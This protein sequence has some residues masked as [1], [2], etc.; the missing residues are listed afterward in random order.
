MNLTGKVPFMNWVGGKRKMVPLLADVFHKTLPDARRLVEPFCGSC[1]VSIG[2][3][4]PSYWLND[5]NSD[6]GLLYETLIEE[7][8]EF[9]QR[10]GEWWAEE[11]Q[12]SENYYKIRDQFNSGGSFPRWKKAALFYWLKCHAHSGVIRYGPKGYNVPYGKGKRP[13]YPAEKLEEF[14]QHFR[15]TAKTT[16]RSFESVLRDC[17]EGDLVYCDPPYTPLKPT[18]YAKY[19][20]G[21]IFAES[22][23][24]ALVQAAKGAVARGAVVLISNHDI[25]A[26]RKLYADADTIVSLTASRSV[27]PSASREVI[28]LIAIYGKEIAMNEDKPAS[29]PKKPSKLDEIK[30]K[31]AQQYH[32]L[33]LEA[34]QEK[35]K[36]F[37]STDLE[38]FIS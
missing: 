36:G 37:S 9:I 26:T 21:P 23:H 20:V 32:Q 31:A 12:T 38:A 17:G 8:G 13:A 22:E 11:E 2:I 7:D 6:L 3:D 33:L 28:E 19:W 16:S 29:A 10:M 30:E 5:I 27:R 14:W 4:F 25:E 1:A 35:L 15:L 34:A 24:E 18:G